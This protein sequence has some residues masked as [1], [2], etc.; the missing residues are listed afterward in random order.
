MRHAC[1]WGTLAVLL[2]PFVFAQLGFGFSDFTVYLDELGAALISEIL[3]VLTTL[4]NDV[5]IVATALLNGLTFTFLGASG[6]FNSIQRFFSW[7]WNNIILTTLGWIL[8]QL[9][10][11]QQWL[12]DHFQWLI[13]FLKRLLQLQQQFYQQFIKPVLNILIRIR[14]F[15]QILRIFHLHI[16]DKLDNWLAGLEA[17]LLGHFLK[18]TQW[19]NRLLSYIE[20]ILDAAGYLKRTL[21]VASVANSASDLLLLFT[22]RTLDYWSGAEGQSDT[23][24][25]VN[26]TPASV[27]QD[28]EQQTTTHTGFWAD[29]QQ[30]ARDVYA[31]GLLS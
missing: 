16:F 28:V 15:I 18:V 7:L 24:Q 13:D 26:F 9:Q 21:L 1:Q 5:V 11:L 14:Q 10:D 31:A 19:I 12:R 2:V 30:N 29:L 4:W 20:L 17:K 3:S 6:L 25:A 27:A 22:G 23:G 8:K